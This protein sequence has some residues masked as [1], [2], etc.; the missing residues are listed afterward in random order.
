MV[1]I[2]HT[3][4]NAT[5]LVVGEALVDIVEDLEGKQNVDPG[6]SPLN[7]AVGLGRRR[8]QQCSPPASATTTM[9]QRSAPTWEALAL[10]A[11]VVW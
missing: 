9:A 5:V 4:T 11:A 6:G 7:V 10:P 1:H 2:H 8:F 3:G